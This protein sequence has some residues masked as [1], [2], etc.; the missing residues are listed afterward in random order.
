MDLNGNIKNKF[1]L[2]A[3]YN[4]FDG[5]ELLEGSIKQI[6]QHVDYVTVVYQT[7]SNF[8]NPCN[9]ELV[10][11]LD[12]LKSEGLIDELFEYKPKVNKGGHYN[13]IE[14]R[15]I[16]LSLSQRAGCT[17]H[18]SM[19]SDEYYTPLEFQRLKSTIEEGGYDSS[20]CQMQTYYKSWEY[21]LDPPETYY[22]SLIFKIKQDSS[23]VL[24]V[25]SPVLVDPTRRMSPIN[26]PLIL[27]RDEIQ[28]HH[29]SYIR[30]DIR[31]KL[32]NSSASVNFNKDID[33]IVG[34]YNNWVYPEKVL[35]GGLPSTLHNVKKVI[36]L[37]L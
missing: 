17:H 33:R 21:S 36:N 26:K 8:G 19:D 25:P 14:K 29:G 34:H 32:T 23:Y 11:L 12:K 5:E 22:V 35:W 2:G 3:S 7:V 27:T 16:G 1:K 6:R 15:N 9:S 20:Y 4:L 18:M 10:P 30:N 28:M 37:F 31:T 13:E 24:G